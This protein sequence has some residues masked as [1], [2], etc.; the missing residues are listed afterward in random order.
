MAHEEALIATLAVSLALAF[1]LGLLA[2]RLRMPPLVGYLL[3]GI[4]LGPHTPGWVADVHLAPQLAEIGVMLLM[5]GVGTHFS[6][7]ELLAV[8]AVA[9][10]GA[11][12]QIAVATALGALLARFWGWPAGAGGEHRSVAAR[13]RGSGHPRQRGRA[14][15]GGL[16]H[17]GGSRDR[18]GA[19]DAARPR[20]R[21]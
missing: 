6:L 4:V 14:H 2:A 13:A 16:A 1:V 10:P 17:R 5:F 15:R 9:L 8:K 12:A 19:G 20:P 21:R 11:L 3:A 7:R 18:A